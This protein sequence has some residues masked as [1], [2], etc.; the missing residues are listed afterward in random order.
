[1]PY[2]LWI[3][4]S[5][6]VIG[7]LGVFFVAWNFGTDIKLTEIPL[8]IVAGIIVGYIAVAFLVGEAV[9]SWIAAHDKVVIRGRKK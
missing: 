7:I 6:I 2:L 1:M 9:M 5:W 4:V 3:A 8:Y